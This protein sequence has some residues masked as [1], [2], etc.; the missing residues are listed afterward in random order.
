MFRAAKRAIYVSELHNRLSRLAAD[1]RQFLKLVGRRGI[2]VYTSFD[3]R[4]VKTR[5]FAL[6]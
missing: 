3:N 6:A 5:W 2:Y 1:I 4:V